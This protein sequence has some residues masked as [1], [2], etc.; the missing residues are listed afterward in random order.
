MVRLVVRD[1]SINSTELKQNVNSLGMNCSHFPQ[2]PA[3][4]SGL[5]IYGVGAWLG[6][7]KIK[8]SYFENYYHHP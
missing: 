8:T 3:R 5:C 6:T 7:L 4:E 2:N 1:I